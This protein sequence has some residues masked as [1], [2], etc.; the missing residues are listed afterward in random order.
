MLVLA[1]LQASSQS[2]P[3]AAQHQFAATC[4]GCHGLDGKGSA[5]GADIATQ[6]KIIT[7][8]D[9]ELARIIHNG[10]PGTGMPSMASLGDEQINALVRYLRTLQKQAAATTTSPGTISVPTASSGPGTTAALNFPPSLTEA[11][12]A[13]LSA[14]DVQPADIAQKTLAENWT[15]YHGDYTG[16]RFSSLDQ[17]T[18]ANASKLKLAWRLHT[19][20]AGTMQATPVVV[21]GVMYVT[22][23]NDVYAVDA[24]T[25]RLLWHHALPVTDGLVDDASGHINRGVAVLGTR[26]YQETDNAQPGLPG[27]AHWRAT[28]GCRIHERQQK[29]WRNQ[30][31]ADR[32]EQSTGQ[33]VRR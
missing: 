22:R 14:I 15:S 17:V 32:E 18:A 11:D 8:P 5:K 20:N 26:V 13:L 33:R 9:A 25:G 21:N 19:Q 3:D 12:R 29:L 16:R 1:I 23:S 31:A 7:L 4:A 30:R 28:V 10:V 6:P 24:A 2:P 27:R